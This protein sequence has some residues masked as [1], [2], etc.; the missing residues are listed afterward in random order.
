MQQN[1][2]TEPRPLTLLASTMESPSTSKIRKSK[3]T[4]GKHLLV[5]FSKCNYY[6]CEQYNLPEVPGLPHPIRL[7]CFNYLRQHPKLYLNNVNT[8][9]CSVVNLKKLNKV[10]LNPRDSNRVRELH[11]TN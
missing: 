11:S 10:S 1:T 2:D 5:S 3:L 6:Y 4:L 7:Q 8:D 9:Y